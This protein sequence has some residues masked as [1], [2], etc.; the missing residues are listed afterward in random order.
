MARRP[1]FFIDGGKAVSKMYEFEW[2]PGFAA[3]QKQKSIDSLHSA[4]RKADAGARPLEISTKG[5]DP[6]GVRLSAFNLRLDGRPLE[7]VFQSAKVFENGGPYPDLLAVPPREAKRDGR[8]KNSG[9]LI[10]FR[11]R[12]EE[13]PLVPRTVFYDCIYLMAVRETLTADEISAIG[14]YDYFTDIEFNPARSVNTQARAVSL[15]KLM[16]D[17]YG[18]LPDFTRDGFIQYHREHIV[19]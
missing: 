8:L 7:N 3:S 19:Y 6:A 17:G 18:G 13:F 9:R 11:Y 5:R 1:A 16:M 2:F 15:I 14:A 4:I 10:G 12:S